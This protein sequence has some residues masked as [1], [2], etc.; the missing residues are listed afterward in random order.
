MSLSVQPGGSLLVAWQLTDRPVLLVGAGEIA[1]QRLAALLSAD[2]LV[3]LVAPCPVHQAIRA[4]LSEYPHRI[5]YHDRPFELIDIDAASPHLVLTA[6]S[7]PVASRAIATHCRALHIPVNVADDPTA[8]D[9]YFGAIVRRGPLQVLISTNGNGPRLA[10]LIK[11]QIEVTL[12]ENVGRAIEKVGILRR[13][14]RERAPEVGGSTGKRRMR[15]ISRVCEI[16][17]FEQLAEMNVETMERLIDEGWE[18]DTIPYPRNFTR[19]YKL[20]SFPSVTSFM[21]GF[22]SG[23]VVC[24]VFGFLTYRQMRQ[25]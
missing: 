15:W 18:K 4:N 11:E 8:C 3:T 24:T 7:D 9:F 14:L 19:A 17:S 6:I 2:A 5:T 25:P 12:P 16:W 1:A 22:A 23:L 20:P 21:T 10:S 13:K